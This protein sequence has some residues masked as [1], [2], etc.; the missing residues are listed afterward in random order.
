[1]TMTTTKQDM[2]A[3]LTTVAA[4]TRASVGPVPFREW[5]R[6]QYWSEM[7]APLPELPEHAGPTIELEPEPTAKII[8]MVKPKPKPASGVSVVRLPSP[9]FT[10]IPD[11]GGPDVA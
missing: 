3:C 6:D 10:V 2:L 8:P 7:R 4:M 11:E 9:F 1:M 5:L